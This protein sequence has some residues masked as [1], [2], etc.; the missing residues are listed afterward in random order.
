MSD[1][2]PRVPIHCT[3]IVVVGSRCQLRKSVFGSNAASSTGTFRTVESVISSERRK[4]VAARLVA[5][6]PRNARR[7][8]IKDMRKFRLG[9]SA[10]RNQYPR[11]PR[12]AGREIS[13]G[14]AKQT[15]Q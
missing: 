15:I 2:S 4:L 9:L 5:V 13:G 12:K 7:E 11:S 3:V 14:H 1:V 6:A 8:R 10:K